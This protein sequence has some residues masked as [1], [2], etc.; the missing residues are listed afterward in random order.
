MDIALEDFEMRV[1]EIKPILKGRF[2][3]AAYY[4]YA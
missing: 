3:T 1:S 2:D 4:Q